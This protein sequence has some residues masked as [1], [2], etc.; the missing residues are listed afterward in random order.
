MNNKGLSYVEMII[1]LAISSILIGMTTITMG[2]VNR[3]NINRASERLETAFNEART[4]AMVY[5]TSKGCLNI[6]NV[7]NV[8]YYNIGPEIS[9]LNPVDFNNQ[10]WIKFA[11]NPIFLISGSASDIILNGDTYTWKFKQ[12]TGELLGV[13][14]PGARQ[15]AYNVYL[16]NSKGSIRINISSITGK[17]SIDY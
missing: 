4:S 2:T 3:A 10:T 17:I 1:V 9:D 13:S 6:T 14:E 12:S 16:A 11:Q 8:L 7:N 15:G 5:G